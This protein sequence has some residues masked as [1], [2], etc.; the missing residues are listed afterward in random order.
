MVEQPYSNVKERKS[1]FQSQKR[2]RI[3]K[4]K[5]LHPHVNLAAPLQQYTRIIMLDFKST[6]T[7]ITK[8]VSQYH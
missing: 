2:K 5:H 4:I 1:H 6:L 8:I 3:L 7:V